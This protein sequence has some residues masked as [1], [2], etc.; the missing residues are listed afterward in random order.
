MKAA[1]VHSFNSPPQ[2]DTFVEPVPTVD[3]T[4]VSVSAA[5]LSPLVKS[6]ASGQ[7]YSSTAIF[8]FIPGVDGVGNLS[9]GTRI[10]FAFPMS[11]YGSMAE[12]ATVQKNLLVPLPADLDDA[13][14]AAIANPG[15]SSWAA[16]TARAKLVSGE[17]VL[18]NGATG[19]AGRLAVQIAKHLGAKKVVATGRNAVRLDALP[20]LGADVVISLEQSEQ[21]LAQRFRQEMGAGVNV[22]LDYLWGKSAEQLIAAASRRGAGQG[23]PRIRYVQVGSISGATIPLPAAAL[24][25]SGLELLGSGLGSLSNER[26]VTAIGELMRAVVSAK[27][28]IEVETISLTEVEA[29]W[30]RDTGERRLVFTL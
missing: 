6:Q 20:A 3:E 16:L 11:P 5:A 22:I 19:S 14:A 29:A 2:Y 8:P 26:L 10:Y 21:E 30:N 4:I 7:H 17:T 23:D 1:V 25:S 15:M 13:T 24:R 27:L 28:L 12:L 9:D 18:V